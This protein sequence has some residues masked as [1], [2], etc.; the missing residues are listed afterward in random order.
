MTPP[1]S[2]LG[3]TIQKGPTRVYFIKGDKEITEYF[4]A[5]N[6]WVNSPPSLPT[7]PSYQRILQSGKPRDFQAPPKQAVDRLPNSSKFAGSYPSLHCLTSS[8]SA[9]RDK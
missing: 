7:K 5:E 9:R 3:A 4:C 6:A 2:V 8:A 1:R